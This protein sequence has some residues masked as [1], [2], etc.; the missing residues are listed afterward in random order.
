MCGI[1]GIYLNTPND[2]KL[3]PQDERE[4]FINGLLKGIEHRGQDATGIVAVQ[5][6]STQPWLEKADITAS[7]FIQYRRPLPEEA[8]IVLCHTRAATKGSPT[9]LDNNHPVVYKTCFVT[10][11]GHIR[12]DDD[13]F[14]DKKLE[15]IAQVD[16]EII[17][18]LIDKH[19]L[20]KVHLALQQLE[21]GFAIAAIQPEKHP[22]VLVLAKGRNSPLV[23]LETEQGLIW[24]SVRSAIKDAWKEVWGQSP[25]DDVFQELKEGELLY[26]EDGKIEKLE[27]KV[28][29]YTTTTKSSWSGSTGGYYVGHD[30]L[31]YQE[32]FCN[33]KLHKRT[34]KCG[35]SQWKHGSRWEGS[36]AVAENEGL[37]LKS[38]C[39]CTAFVFD[40]F[41]TKREWKKHEDYKRV[42]EARVK[43]EAEKK[44]VK[45]RERREAQDRARIAAAADRRHANRDTDWAAD[46][47]EVKGALR[48]VYESGTSERKVYDDGHLVAV[49]FLCDGCDHYRPTRGR[50]KMGG[51]SLC[52]ECWGEECDL[53]GDF[54][55]PQS[56]TKVEVGSDTAAKDEWYLCLT[57]YNEANVANDDEFKKLLEGEQ[58]Q[59][60][61]VIVRTGASKGQLDGLTVDNMAIKLSAE[62]L[63]CTANFLYELLFDMDAKEIA[64]E[65]WL[66]QAYTI[67]KEV[68][69][70]TL[71]EL[72]S[73]L[74]STTQRALNRGSEDEPRSVGE[75]VRH[76]ESE[77]GVRVFTDE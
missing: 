12:N 77:V 38:D 10:H 64:D 35:H 56:L 70:R 1:A 34:C 16:S 76:T 72:R 26:V 54:F 47:P 22:D 5:R 49:Q 18:A 21:G 31:K 55:D 61:N 33:V 59:K 45:E 71:V 24:A 68:Y 15:R 50:A 28:K 30:H 14:E 41:L 11:N 53:C 17:P 46:L 7:T 40:R 32:R 48:L 36:R 4:A 25:S 2:P 63:G 60:T 62:E 9:N 75:A 27:F 66:A 44:A 19:G 52:V 37:C 39:R 69:K 3:P 20:D 23:Y 6:A 73:G 67:S 57:C 43:L 42:Q 65:T 74:P 51:Y 29:Q 58:E 8:R 13:L